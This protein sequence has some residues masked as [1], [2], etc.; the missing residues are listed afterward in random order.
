MT[1]LQTSVHTSVLTNFRVNKIL[2]S[3]RNYYKNKIQ[4]FDD[5]YI[6]FFYFRPKI[7]KAKIGGPDIIRRHNKGCNC[8]RSGCLKNYCECYEVRIERLL[9]FFLYYPEK[10][11]QI[12]THLIISLTNTKSSI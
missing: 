11:A 3:M 5:S 7:G 1:E 9:F 6:F 10:Y 4:L 2:L 12:I 8:K